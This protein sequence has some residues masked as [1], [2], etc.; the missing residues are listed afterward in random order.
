MTEKEQQQYFTIWTMYWKLFRRYSTFNGAETD[1]YWQK[2]IDEVGAAH[3]ELEKI[4][5]DLSKRMAVLTLISIQRLYRQKK[6]ELEDQVSDRQMDIF[7]LSKA[8]N[9]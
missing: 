8:K 6:E 5:H 1:E 2:L 3:K 9:E 4:D 7:D